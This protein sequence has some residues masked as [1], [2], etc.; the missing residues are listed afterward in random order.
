MKCGHV[1]HEAIQW[2]GVIAQCMSQSGSKG[3]G[4][5]CDEWRSKNYGE[6]KLKS[7]FTSSL[8]LRDIFLPPH[9]IR[10]LALQHM[11]KCNNSNAHM[12]LNPKCKSYKSA[13]ACNPKDEKYGHSLHITDISNNSKFPSFFSAFLYHIYENYVSFLRLYYRF[14]STENNTV[15]LKEHILKLHEAL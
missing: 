14:I 3:G 12:Q 2:E 1:E 8:P 5:E 10:R 13:E 15:F 11:P 9:S 4:V 6:R 7:D